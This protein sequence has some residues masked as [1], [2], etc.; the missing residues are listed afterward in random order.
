MSDGREGSSGRALKAGVALATGLVALVAAVAGLVFDFWPSLRPD[1]RSEL[2]A[3]IVVLAV[4][5]KVS[6]REWMRR[7][8][9]TSEEYQR[10]RDE[11]L[12]E[13]ESPEGLSIRGFVAYAEVSVRGFKRRTVVLQYAIYDRL[14]QTRVWTSRAEQG[15]NSVISLDA[16]RD[17]FVAELWVQPVQPPRR[18]YF[19]RVE[20]REPDGGAL[21][22]MA[23]SR[24]FRGLS[25]A[26]IAGL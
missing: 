1:P 13:T 21:L 18:S 9:G 11:A 5:R 23:D 12:P 2:G 6:V 25:A 14:S 22:A 7:A 3:D 8:A 26:D 10:R 24:P 15:Q 4:E 20:V 16:P 17:E 19:L